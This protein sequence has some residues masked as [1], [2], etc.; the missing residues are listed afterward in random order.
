[1]AEVALRCG[2]RQNGNDNTLKVRNR[3]VNALCHALDENRKSTGEQLLYPE[4]IRE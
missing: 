4:R 3:R 1:M 2:H